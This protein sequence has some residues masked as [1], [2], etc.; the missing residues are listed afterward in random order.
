MIS[1]WEAMKFGLMA[2]GSP[3]NT[4]GWVMERSSMQ[5]EAEAAEIKMG[6]LPARKGEELRDWFDIL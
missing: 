3:R 1:A 6:G 5:P 4:V 2:S